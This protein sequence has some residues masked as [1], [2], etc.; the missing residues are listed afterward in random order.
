MNVNA[1]TAEDLYYSD[2]ID[3]NVE[4]TVKTGMLNE[5]RIFQRKH[6]QWSQLWWRHIKSREWSDVTFRSSENTS[7]LF[8]VKMTSLNFYCIV[9]FYKESV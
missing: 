1:R 4:R 6:Y 5:T 8:S 3:F 2:K 9:H 7:F